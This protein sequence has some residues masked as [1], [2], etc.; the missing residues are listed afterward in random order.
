MKCGAQGNCGVHQLANG[1]FVEKCHCNSGYFGDD[2]SI[3]PCLNV[4]CENTGTC[5]SVSIPDGTFSWYCKC[6]N[7]H[8][9][10][11]CQ[12]GN[13]QFGV[14]NRIITSSPS[15]PANLCSPNPCVYDAKFSNDL[16]ALTCE[17]INLNVFFCN[18]CSNPACSFTRCAQNPCPSGFKCADIT[19]GYACVKL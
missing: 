6:P 19:A 9:G 18:G 7:T 14:N 12:F 17:I 4:T 11:N 5:A 16:Q 8:F 3:N 2:C 15:A 10:R 1:T 13:D